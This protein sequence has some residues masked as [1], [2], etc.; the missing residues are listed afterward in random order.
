MEIMRVLLGV[1]FP[2]RQEKFPPGILKVTLSQITQKFMIGQSAASSLEP[3]KRQR[4]LFPRIY[5]ND[6]FSAGHLAQRPTLRWRMP[7]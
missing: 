6:G 2:F 5:N 4:V 7:T 3:G 1:V